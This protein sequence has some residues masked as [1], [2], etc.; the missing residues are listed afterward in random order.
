VS[1][2]LVV[3]LGGANLADEAPI[4]T[5]V[6]QQARRRPVV[7]VHGGG[8][9]VTDWQGRLGV[10]ARFEEGLRVTD[11]ATLEVAQAVL[12]GLVN[13]ELV[14]ALRRAGADAVGLSGIDGG[15]LV[16]ERVPG[17]G[18]VAS[19]VDIRRG[20][21]DALLVAGQ[22][23]V[24][25]PL[26]LDQEGITCNVN[27]DDV[28]AGIAH[29]IG[30]R[31]LV[32]LSDV[33]GVHGEAGSP[34]AAI[35]AREAAHLLASGVIHG[36]MVPKVRAALRAV[37][38][39]PG[40]EAIIADGGATDALTRALEDASFGTRIR[41]AGVTESG[42]GSATAWMI[43]PPVSGRARKGRSGAEDTAKPDADSDH[44]PRPR[45]AKAG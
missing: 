21:L 36:G 35:D 9:R 32:L 37:A 11:A 12:G 15:L 43:P 13:G 22:L 31:Q 24:I 39:D 1:D 17:K 25:A 41:G 40:A 4:L 6:A 38:D 8:A 18:L 34:L 30:A 23:P 3:K 7:V 28:A 2:V 45:W 20:L 42:P 19:V 26:A 14:A 29:G 27:A 16:A 5:A 10:E 33:A 44:A